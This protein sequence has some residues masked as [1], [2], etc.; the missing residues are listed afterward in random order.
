[1]EGKC[2]YRGRSP[3]L[4]VSRTEKSAEVILVISNEPMNKAEVSQNDEGL[5]VNWFTIRTGLSVKRYSHPKRGQ[6]MH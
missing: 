4:R 5:N 6:V 2:S 1:M 3:K